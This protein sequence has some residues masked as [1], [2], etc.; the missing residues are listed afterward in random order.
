MS[1]QIA[2]PGS[3]GTFSISG[4]AWRWGGR[5][6]DRARRDGARGL[7]STVDFQVQYTY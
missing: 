5:D 1:I 2:G 3:G 7:E 4:L 6:Y